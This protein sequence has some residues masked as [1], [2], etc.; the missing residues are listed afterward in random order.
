MQSKVKEGPLIF[1]VEENETKSRTKLVKL[2]KLEMSAYLVK[3][4]VQ[5][6]QK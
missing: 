1:L 4:K 6:F 3:K 2:E 5:P